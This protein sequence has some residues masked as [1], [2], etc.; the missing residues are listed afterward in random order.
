MRELDTR[1]PQLY[2]MALESPNELKSMRMSVSRRHGS[3]RQ[4]SPSC[5]WF[6][7]VRA[8][9]ICS[10]AVYVQVKRTR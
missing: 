9:F 7:A 10:T 5:P 1:S 3:M 2:A 6:M 8:V 4:L